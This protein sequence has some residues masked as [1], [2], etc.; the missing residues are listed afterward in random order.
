MSSPAVTDC[1]KIRYPTRRAA[2]KAARQIRYGRR[3]T[4]Y[5]CDDCPPGFW[6]LTSQTTAQKTRW[7]RYARQGG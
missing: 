4:A 7:R 6:H 5:R 3:L 1:A 2:R